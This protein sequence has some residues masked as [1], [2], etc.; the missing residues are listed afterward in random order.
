VAIGRF[1]NGVVGLLVNTG[2][3][4]T[5][6]M[7]LFLGAGTVLA[8]KIMLL[9]R[10]HGCEDNF[11]RVCSVVSGLWMANVIAFLFLHGDSEYAMKTFSLHAGML[12]TCYHLLKRRELSK[13]YQS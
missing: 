9:L 6:F 4:G 8:L 1:Y 12:L 11:E 3:F 7:L 13:E 5:A 10:A 2:I